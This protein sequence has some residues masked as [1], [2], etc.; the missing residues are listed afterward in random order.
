MASYFDTLT[1]EQKD[2]I[3]FI[4]GRMKDKGLSNPFTQTGILSVVSKE[5]SFVPKSENG[6]SKTS[7]AR[8][9]QIFG[10]RVSKYNEEQLTKLK[11]DDVAFF[12]AVYGLPQFGQTS[13][14]GH[15][16]R[17]RGLNQLTFKKSYKELGEQIG[18]DLLNHPDKLNEMPVATDC[19]I[20]FFINAFRQAPKSKLALYNTTDINGF[21]S[22]I[23]GVGAV[24]HANSGW[25]QSKASIDADPTGGRKKAIE[26]GEGFLRIVLSTK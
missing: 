9:R 23:D 3:H 17:G 5:S 8:I 4:I 6:Y 25:G 14:E 1:K 20:Q 12:N 11:S 18:V 10:S 22:L 24:Y 16:Y 26:R 7:N 15:L 19:L 2:N 21:K 13:T